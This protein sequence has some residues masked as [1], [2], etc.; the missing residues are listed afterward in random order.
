MTLCPEV[1]FEGIGHANGIVDVQREVGDVNA[2]A[3]PQAQV[4]LTEIL[5]FDRHHRDFLV[6]S[7]SS[8]VDVEAGIEPPFG[9][10]CF[11]QFVTGHDGYFGIKNDQ[12]VL[13]I[14]IVFALFFRG[15]GDAADEVHP[16]LTKD[17]FFGYPKIDATL[18]TYAKEL[19]GIVEA[20]LQVSTVDPRLKAELEVGALGVGRVC[21]QQ[22]SVSNDYQYLD[23]FF[24]GESFAAASLPYLGSGS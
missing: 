11:D 6:E 23:N 12:V 4:G 10:G 17:P 24:H 15:K 2:G 19:G 18:I 14:N 7:F 5:A 13:Q 21:T 20:C 1:K 8:K 9:K 22:E 16:D 3:Y